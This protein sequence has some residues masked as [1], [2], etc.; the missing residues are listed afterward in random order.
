[1]ASLATQC[2]CVKI[3]FIRSFP[4]PYYL[5]FGLNTKRYGVSLLIQS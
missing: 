5:A 1:M 2:H 4:G 3:G